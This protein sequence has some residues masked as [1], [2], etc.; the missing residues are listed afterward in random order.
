MPSVAWRDADAHTR[1]A[2]GLRRRA[3]LQQLRRPDRRGAERSAVVD[4]A[5][6]AG[7]TFFDTADVYGNHGGSET[8]LGDVLQGRR[9][10]VVLATKCGSDMGDG[11][12]QRAA[13]ASYIRGRS[14]RRCSGLQTD[15][16]DLYQ[17]HQEDP[18]DAARGDVRRAR[19]ARREGKIRAVRHV[20]LRSRRR[21]SAPEAIARRR[22]YVSEQSE[23]SWLAARGGAR[24]AADLRGARPRLHPVL[25]ARER[26][27]SPARSR[28]TRRR[29]RDAAARPRD[30][31]REARPR[32]AARARGPRRTA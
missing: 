25:P 17:H 18:R 14:T 21:S 31:R 8:I 22:R 7:V 26:A 13:R 11:A 16:I 32:R 29:P 2:R 12:D 6:E 20:E 3:R 23:Y 24:A 1:P 19:R 28:A 10:Q 9:D 4:A 30:R 27:C 15:V 5:L